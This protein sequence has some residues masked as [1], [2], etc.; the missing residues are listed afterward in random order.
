MKRKKR[1]VSELTRASNSL[2]YEIWMLL[3]LGRIMSVGIGRESVFI[4]NALVESFMIHA[5]VMLEFLYAENPRKD[6][7][8]AEDFLP[9][10]EQWQDIRIP[11][12]ELLETVHNRVSKEAV[13]LTYARLEQT[14]E[15]KQ[16]AF[17]QIAEDFELVFDQF[18]E[19]VPTYLLGSRWEAQSTSK[20]KQEEE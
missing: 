4:N 19:L 12:T 9:D 15:T 10:T 18:L 16:W 13:H 3:N 6:D 11:K 17:L 8:V 2:Y 1:K 14:P 5:R 7:I 20:D